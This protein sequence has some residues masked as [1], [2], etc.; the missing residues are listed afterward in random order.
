ML[1]LAMLAMEK[2]FKH[3]IQHIKGYLV[4]QNW[5]NTMNDES[6]H[7]EGADWMINWWDLVE[8]EE[9]DLYLK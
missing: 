2:M 9:L 5:I 8:G 3:N 6:I 7:R 4:K 1:G